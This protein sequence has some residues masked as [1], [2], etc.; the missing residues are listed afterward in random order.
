MMTKKLAEYPNVLRKIQK[1]EK[2]KRKEKKTSGYLPTHYCQQNK[3]S[4][5]CCAWRFLQTEFEGL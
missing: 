4:E 5:R 1:K 3:L 2:E